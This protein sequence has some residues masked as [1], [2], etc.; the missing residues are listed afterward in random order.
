VQA[1]VSPIGQKA[2]EV[3]AILKHHQVCRK[4]QESRDPISDPARSCIDER[5]R[6]RYTSERSKLIRFCEKRKIL[7]LYI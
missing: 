6:G 3:F 5:G 7:S 4:P 1:I 2:G